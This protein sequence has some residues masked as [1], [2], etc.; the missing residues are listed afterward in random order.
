[1][2]ARLLDDKNLQL[3]R[4]FDKKSDD[5]QDALL[6]E[7][8]RGGIARKGIARKGIAAFPEVQP[9]KE[10]LALPGLCTAWSAIDHKAQPGGHGHCDRCSV[11]HWVWCLV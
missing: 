4:K 1:M 7:V 5:V 8:R 9:V 11:I 6:K 10:A 3:I 2:S